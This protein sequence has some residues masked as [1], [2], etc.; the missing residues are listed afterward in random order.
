MLRWTTSHGRRA[1]AS[2]FF[3]NTF[4][5]NWT[6]TWPCSTLVRAILFAAVKSALT[7]T[8]D[9]HKRV[10]ATID[11]YFS[12]VGDDAEAFRLLFETDLFNER[13]VRDRVE[14]TDDDC[15]ELL[16][17]VIA[18]DTGLPINE[19]RL[20]AFALIG[21]FLL[22]LRDAGEQ[23]VVDSGRSDR[24]QAR[25]LTFDQRQRSGDG[26][27][28][29]HPVTQMAHQCRAPAPGTGPATQP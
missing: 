11:A 26:V 16:T 18:E 24:G 3:T 5:A 10:L 20:L 6:S 8:T 25:V 27:P 9:N 17:G 28:L 12:F 21:L 19:A 1:S 13:E 15:A 22:H 14:K 2:Q 4:P 23:P 29:T 7:S